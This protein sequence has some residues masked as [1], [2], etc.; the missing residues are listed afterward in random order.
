MTIGGNSVWGEYFSGRIDEVRIYNRALSQSEIQSDMNTS[1]TVLPPDTTP[2]T[3]PAN[4]S[5]TAAGSSQINLSWTAATD[6]VGVT[7]YLIERCQGTGCSTFTQIATTTTTTY[8]NTGLQAST[9][10]SYRVRAT[11]AANNLSLYSNT[12][13]ATTQQASDTTPPTAPANLSATAAGSSQINL[14]WT[15][16]TD[17]VGVTGYLIERCQGTGCSTFTQIATTTTTTYNNAGLQAS[18]SYSYRV[19]A[20]DAANNLGPYSSTATTLTL[21]AGVE[22]AG[23]YAGDMHV[24]RSCGGT[25]E[26]LSS[27]YQRMAPNNL[28]VIS[29]L[30]DMGNGEV[31]DPVTDLPRVNGSDDPVSTP[32]QIVHWDTEWHWDP[33]YPQFPH[34]ALGGHI[35]ALGLTQ[36]SQVWEE[37]TYP[38]FNWAHQRGGIAGFAHMQYL[39]GTNTIA[40]GLTCCTPIEYPVEVALGSSDF[41]SEDVDD[42]NSTCGGAAS[43]GVSAPLYPENAML[44]YYKLLNCGFRPGFAGG[45]DYP[46]N[47]NNPLGSILTYAQ[48]AGGQ[49]TYSN[50]VQ[51][52]AKGRT[53]VSRNG[54]NEFMSLLVNNSASPG[55]EIKLTGAGSVQVSIQ[56]TANQTLTGTI[57]LVQNGVVVASQP[58]SVSQGV[59]ASLNTT[60]NF[61]NSGWLAARRMDSIK[62]HMVHTAAVFVTINNAPVRASVADAQFYVGWMDNLLTKTSPGG[63]WNQYF[64]TNLVAAQAR[65]SAAKALYQQI[66]L[67][68]GGQPTPVTITTTSLSGGAL[69]VSYSATLAAGGGATPYTWSISSGSLPAGLSLNSGTGVVSGTPTAPGTYNF[70]ARVADSGNPIQTAT[71]DLSISVAAQASNT[72][73]PST[74]V[75]SLV[76]GG[77]DSSV[78]LGV[79]FQADSSGFITGIR[80]YKASTNTGTHVGNLWTSTG[81]KLATATFA[82]ETASGWQQVIFSS[83]VA[84]TANTV[85]I[86]SYHAGVGHYSADVNYFAA[87]GKDSPPLH[88]LANG[89]SGGN[90]VYAYGSTS[91]FPNQTW[92]SANYYV[93]VLFSPGTPPTL[94]SIA[95]MPV[96][97]TISTGATQQFTAMGTYSDGSTQNISS[98]AAWASSSTAAATISGT[99]LATAVGPGTTTITAALSGVIAGTNLTV[100]APPLTITTQSLP[101]GILNVSYSATLSAVGGTSPYTWSI[102]SGSLP[103]GLSLNTSTGVISGSP[104]VG[105]AFNFIAQAT[106]SSNTAQTATRALSI[107]AGPAAPILIISSA[108]NPFSNYYTEILRAEG[109]DEFAVDDISSVSSALLNAFDIVILGDMALTSGQVSI[110]SDWVNSGGYLIAMHPDKKLAGL[111]GLT[112]QSLS[113]AN[114]YLL[115]NTSTGPGV[116]IVNQTIQYHGSADLYRISTA[117]NLA[118]L[119]SNATTSTSYAAVSL[120]NV[121][122]SGGQAAAFAYDLARS[123]VYTRQGNPAWAGQTRDGLSPMRSDDLFYGAANFDPQ[124]DWVDLNKVAIPQADEQQR[125]LANLIIQMNFNKKPL[126]RFWYLPRNLAAAVVMTGDDHGSFYSGGATAA[127]F[128]QFI[129]ASP[130]GCVVDNWECVRGSAYVF[131]PSVASNPL[132]NAQAATYINSGFEIGVHV[133]SST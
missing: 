75:P 129:A 9:S 7:G 77:P 61:A 31:Q 64:P 131:P 103:A 83:P 114:A 71:K 117:S 50:W 133:D 95:L 52:I 55:D 53:V 48:V 57:E 63:A 13:S 51:G 104:T 32:G 105:G 4:L 14:S 110:L 106:D 28:A 115:V 99:G 1:I 22:P 41:I 25:P 23:W 43:P 127:R 49:M 10:Y 94:S 20:T 18:T 33:T 15:A 47:C 66:A 82:N 93:D 29:L 69:G 132:S 38:I 17:N 62:G 78:E 24:H 121:G 98:Q 68:A 6:N 119:Y 36:A 124:P 72:I 54:H 108:S 79:K 12:S 87:S 42:C 113:M 35:V 2:P 73:W 5:A 76:D 130:Q 122:T 91:S 65:Y 86:A 112:D 60:V 11:D 88:A 84:V 58:A 96:S 109:F 126:P 101:G 97:Q 30:A 3:A 74:T 45:T 116:G 89:V 56:W 81:T 59:P 100:Q 8:N 19:R 111:L 118:T 92:N 125:L 39:D 34:H 40:N 85:Y 107:A 90:G 46:C 26:T 70:T 102:S 27:M 80:F 37:Y 16:A 123:V 128:D 67:E 21:T 44:A 120:N